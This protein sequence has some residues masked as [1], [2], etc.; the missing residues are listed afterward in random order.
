MSFMNADWY[1][2]DNT[3]VA[4]EIITK[5]FSFCDKDGYQG[6]I[7]SDIAISKVTNQTKLVFTIDGIQYYVN[8]N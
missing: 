4:P 1:Y 7:L 8:A 3:I 6:T 2:F 5:S